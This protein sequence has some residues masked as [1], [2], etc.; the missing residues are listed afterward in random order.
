MIT[1]YLDEDYDDPQEKETCLSCAC[2]A[3]RKGENQLYCI[4]TELDV[5][6]NQP[7]CEMWWD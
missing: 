2:S 6:E 3:Y 5:E 7:A 1:D 4:E